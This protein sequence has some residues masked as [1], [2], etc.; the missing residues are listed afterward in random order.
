[1]KMPSPDQTMSGS[2]RTDAGQV[3]SP[4]D[5]GDRSH[6][7]QT[8]Q[9]TSSVVHPKRSR[10]RHHKRSLSDHQKR[11]R[12]FTIMSITFAAVL[13]LCVFWLVSKIAL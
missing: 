3:L 12:F 10:Q 11:I 6:F 7:G 8:T 13:A 4:D 2:H 1:M 5:F 9:Y